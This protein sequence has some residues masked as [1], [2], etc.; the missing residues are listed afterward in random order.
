MIRGGHTVDFL[1]YPI[2][3][4]SIEQHIR[5]PICEFDRYFRI[6]EMV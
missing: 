6:V 3:T 1:L 2:E 5:S 4:W